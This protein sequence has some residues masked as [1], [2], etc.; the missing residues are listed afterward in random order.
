MSEYLPVA[1]AS[2]IVDDGALHRRAARVGAH[3]DHRELHG[4]AGAQRAVARV[5]AD[6][7]AVELL[8]DEVRALGLGRDHHAGRRGRPC[9]RGDAE[10]ARQ[11]IGAGA[12]REQ[13]AAPPAPA[14]PTAWRA[15]QPGHGLGSLRQLGLG[16]QQTRGR[17]FALGGAQCRRARAAEAQQ[18]REPGRRF[19]RSVEQHVVVGGAWIG[20]TAARPVT[21]AI[22]RAVK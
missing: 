13:H 1:S 14:A 7:R 16:A 10:R 15:Q 21:I 5:R 11:A 8:V 20:S 18:L 2:Q 19:Q 9:L 22:A 12:L 6:V 4:D 17:R 3:D